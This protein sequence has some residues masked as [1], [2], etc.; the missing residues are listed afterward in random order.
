M[1]CERN[2]CLFIRMYNSY[3]LLHIIYNYTLYLYDYNYISFLKFSDFFISNFDSIYIFFLSLLHE[4]R[5]SQF[6]SKFSSNRLSN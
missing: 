4:Y 2:P 5:F 3:I 6:L 1:L